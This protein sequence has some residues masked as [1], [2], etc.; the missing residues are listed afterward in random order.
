MTEPDIRILLV[1]DHQILREGLRSLLD[2][3]PD[4]KVVA[5]AGSAKESIRLTVEFVPDIVVMD[6]GLPDMSGLEAIRE[7]RRLCPGV[8]TVVLSM[9]TQREFVLQAIEAGCD[10]YVPKSTA[11]TSL[12]QAIRTVQAGE[13][14]LHP[15]VATVLMESLTNNP[16]EA[17]QFNQLSDRERDVLKLTAQGYISRE[18]AEQL[19]L[20]PKTVETYRQRAMEKLGLEHR[21]DLIRFALRAGILDEYKTENEL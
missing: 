15:K 6:L 14:F 1:D 17:N 3:E 19:L 18:I 7:I 8:R 16:T 10:G 11:H 4:M 9:H 21:S 2:S 13:R 20:S 5:E 12:L